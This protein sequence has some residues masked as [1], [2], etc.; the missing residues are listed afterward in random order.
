MYLGSIRAEAELQQL[1]G[2]ESDPEIRRQII[3]GLMASQSAKGLVDIARK[4]TNPE[5][6]REAVQMLSSMKTKEA[7]DYLMELVSK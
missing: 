4:E 7:T 6:K 5:L 2:S 3:H 1:Y